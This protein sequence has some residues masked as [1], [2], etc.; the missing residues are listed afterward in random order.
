M[1]LNLDSIGKKIGPVSKEYTWK[2]VILYA[3]GV[4][5]GF[6]DLDYCYEKNLKV[7]PTFS[8]ATIFD[9]LSHYAA[10][11]NIN[12]AG[13]LHGEQDLIFHQPIPTEGTLTTEGKITQIY[14][15]GEKKGALI[16]GES[17]TWHSNGKKLFTSI[18]T[19]FSRFDGGFGGDDAP[20]EP[21]EYPDRQPDFEIEETP[22]LDQPLLYRLSGD[23]FALHVDQEFAKMAGFE[24]PIM[25]GLCTYGYSCR[26]LINSLTPGEPEKVRRLKCR[27]SRPLYP[28]DPIKIQIWKTDDNHAVW[29]TVN[30]KT[31]EDII[32]NGL[33]EF[34]EIP[35]KEIRF[36]GQVAVITGAGGGLGRVYAL[37]LAKRGAKVVVNDLGGAR[38]GSGGGSATPAQK[39]VEEINAFGGEAVAN[40]DN[41]ATPE[42]GENIIKTAVDTFGKVDILIN[43][44]GIL[45]DKSF[46]KM[47]SENWQ[48]VL[49][50]HLNGAYHVSRP[51]FKIMRENGF[52]RIVMTTSA[53]GLYGNF[54]QTNYSS[55]KM[56]LVGLMNTLKLEGKK[57]DIKVNTVAP[58]AASRL[59][60]DIMPPELFEKMKP[61]FVS[62]LVL[63]LC[64]KECQENGNI[65]NAGMGFFNRVAVVTGPGTTVGDGEN[66]PDIET[67]VDNLDAISSLKNGK[68][69]FELNEQVGD[70]M[71]AFNAPAS[72][73][74]D[75]GRAK[76]ASA[77]EI[78]AAM[79]DA[80]NP[81]AAKGVDVVF[82]YHISGP[83]G[84]DWSCTVKDATC[85]IHQGTHEKPTCTLKIGA[86]D[87]VD[88][89]GG[90]LPAMQAYTSGK[91][92]IEGDVM[93]SQLIEK[94]FKLN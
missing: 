10:N 15:K 31:G 72:S 63:L 80:F 91:L 81:D 7:I 33:F 12:L 17:D 41:V 66:P 50:V 34:G 3:L 9:F 6:S 19:L 65:Y 2:D 79:P 89:I 85:T 18:I 70:A 56:G 43:N 84:G 82:Q 36:D 94:L 11:A 39:V 58:I 47:T 92:K 38:D 1:A 52:G 78:F 68:V 46:V 88:M 23:V 57:Y 73:D 25:H 87:F 20:K 77:A 30:A 71:N 5:A 45:R 40:Y 86:S 55:A 60:E 14:D 27:F 37:E 93:K 51:A 42:G 49:D 74:K 4:G 83:D 53:A 28:G 61:E 16:V 24:K 76:L 48:A 54:G 64:S 67:V 26:S 59:T 29:K 62:P 90:A 22:S 35:K 75:S 21:F 8:I 13:I 44:A 69:Y 32:T